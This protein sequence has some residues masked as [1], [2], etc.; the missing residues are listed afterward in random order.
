MRN[1]GQ[2]IKIGISKVPGAGLGA[3][4]GQ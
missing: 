4:A 1:F 3:F 2:S